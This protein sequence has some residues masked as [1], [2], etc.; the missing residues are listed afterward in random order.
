VHEKPRIDRPEGRGISCVR[1]VN[2][3]DVLAQFRNAF[4]RDRRLR[5]VQGRAADEAEYSRQ[6][7]LNIRKGLS[8]A[9]RR[10]RRDILDAVRAIMKDASIPMSDLFEEAEDE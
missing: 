1:F 3:I 5:V 7:L 9:S 8:K 6:H 10:C 4:Q 2:S